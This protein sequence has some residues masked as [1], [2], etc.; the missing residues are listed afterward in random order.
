M[1][2]TQ[3]LPEYEPGDPKNIAGTDD[4]EFKVKDGRLFLM[5]FHGRGPMR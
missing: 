3:Q 2:A 1:S 4:L 5:A